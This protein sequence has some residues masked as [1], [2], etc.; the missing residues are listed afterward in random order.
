[1]K[2]SELKPCASCDGKLVP[3]WYVVRISQATLNPS[4]TNST[5]GLVQH[6]GGLGNAGALAVAEAMSPDSDCVMVLGDKEPS[7]MT[8]LAICQKCAL[9]KD[10]NIGV[11]MESSRA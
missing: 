11:L 4:A 9:M 5:L 1:M 6:F 2:L 10:L 3:I 8:E 7:L